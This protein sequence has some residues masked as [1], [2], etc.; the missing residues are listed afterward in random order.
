MLPTGIAKPGSA[1]RA[2]THGAG[3]VV[4]GTDASPCRKRAVRKTAKK[5]KVMGL[6]LKPISTIP[7]D[8]HSCVSTAGFTAL[9]VQYRLTCY[10]SKTYTE[11]R[12]SWVFVL[13]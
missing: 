7:S 4:Q 13:V 3:G 1:A 10:S 11:H 8:D 6:V 2:R 12:N 5:E 9:H